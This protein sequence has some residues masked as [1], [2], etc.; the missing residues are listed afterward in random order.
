MTAVRGTIKEAVKLYRHYVRNCGA[1]IQELPASFDPILVMHITC[2]RGSYDVNVEPAK[3]EVMFISPDTILNLVELLFKD[4]Y[5]EHS[6]SSAV[7]TPLRKADVVP[8]ANESFSLL[9][10]KR[11]IPSI[12]PTGQSQAPISSTRSLQPSYSPP[13]AYKQLQVES[14]SLSLPDNDSRGSGTFSE[15]DRIVQ[16]VGRRVHSNMYGFDE[17]GEIHSLSPD[18]HDADNDDGD[19][20]DV[21]ARNPWSLAKLNAPALRPSKM[22]ASSSSTAKQSTSSASIEHE[23]VQ[24]YCTPQASTHRQ[25]LGLRPQL[26]SPMTSPRSPE[27]FQNPGPPK[28]PWPSRQRREEASGSESEPEIPATPVTQD[29]QEVARPLDN[30]AKPIIPRNELPGFKRVS[31][32]YDEDGRFEKAQDTESSEL[33]TSISQPSRVH[34]SVDI[35]NHGRP[36]HKGPMGRPFRSPL[37]KPPAGSNTD[38]DPCSPTALRGFPGSPQTLVMP[39]QSRNPELDQ[40]MEFEHR[41]KAANA[42]Q[43]KAFSKGPDRGMSIAKLAQ[44]QR[45][46]SHPS[47]DDLNSTKL[48]GFQ[49]IPNDLESTANAVTSFG[50]KFDEPITGLNA[51]TKSNPHRNRYLSAAKTL[52]KSRPHRSDVVTGISDTEE[53]MDDSDEISKMPEDDPRAYLM[54]H[55]SQSETTNVD[56]LTRT[57]LKIRRTKTQRLPLESIPLDVVLHDMVA[58]VDFNEQVCTETAPGNDQYNTTGKNDFI[59]WNLAVTD[60]QTWQ[61]ELTT[62]IENMYRARVGDELIPPNPGLDLRRMIKMHCDGI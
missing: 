62:L 59:A 36:Q 20:G 33:S 24:L 44:L 7:T 50:D 26:P 56:G 30:W 48:L 53:V 16:A 43:R 52:T 4:Y 11:S 35:T 39:P 19:I 28:R 21:V 46:T 6:Q 49:K 3:D 22:D 40:I 34:T 17:D 38:R 41:K 13:D 9:L 1:N 58:R 47:N 61:A 32:K 15:E 14:E 27:V 2:P 10:A 42:Q 12:E 25:P 29:G 31:G 8:K 45:S 37:L 23:H 51:I 54:R 55:R 57:G 5:G 60:V 18:P